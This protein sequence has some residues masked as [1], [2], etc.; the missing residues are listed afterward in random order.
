MKLGW[1]G[2]FVLMTLD[3]YFEYVSERVGLPWSEVEKGWQRVR[4][5][6]P[7]YEC[8]HTKARLQAKQV[9]ENLARRKQIIDLKAKS[10]E[11]ITIEF[12]EIKKR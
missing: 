5:Y 11:Q 4:Q 7:H 1:L 9:W 6:T 12:S 2:F 10:S 8:K 3:I